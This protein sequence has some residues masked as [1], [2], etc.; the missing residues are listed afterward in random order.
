MAEDRAHPTVLR[1]RVHREAGDG[2]LAAKVIGVEEI[3]D[4]RLAPPYDVAHPPVH[5]L[6]VVAKCALPEA[7]AACGYPQVARLGAEVLGRDRRLAA[8]PLSVFRD[9]VPAQQHADSSA[10][11]AQAQA[12]VDDAVLVLDG[13]AAARD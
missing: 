3:D 11:V 5:F 7:D 4:E 2:A 13:G 6:A 1:H 8:G 12:E 9:H 10:D